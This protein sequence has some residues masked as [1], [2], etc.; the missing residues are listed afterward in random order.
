MPRSSVSNTGQQVGPLT[1][2]VRGAEVSARLLVAEEREHKIA[3]RL[4]PGRHR[5]QRGGDDMAAPPF[6]SSA[7]R[8][9]TNPSATSPANGGCVHRWPVVATT[10][11]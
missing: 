11:T 9:H 6:M 1:H 7:P 10:S 4:H 5:P 3:R 8:P 2:E